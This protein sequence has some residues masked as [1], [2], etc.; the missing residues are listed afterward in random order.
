MLAESSIA[1]V[2]ADP[3]TWLMP[4]RRACDRWGIETTRQQAA[5]LGQCAYE[6]ERFKVLV[7]NLRYSAYGMLKVFPR[8]VTA[9]EAYAMAFDDVK[10][11]NRVYANRLGNGDEASGD[12]FKYRGRGLLQVTGRDNYTACGV[13]LGIDLVTAPSMLERPMYAALSAGWFWASRRCNELV[14]DI[15]A[16]TRIINGGTLGLAERQLLCAKAL[17][18]MRVA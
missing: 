8:R 13:A 2:G 7:E 15:P 10:I 18:S 4:M 17:D 14:D 9:E 16:L 3:G 12:G 5:F 6:S 11:G 1:A